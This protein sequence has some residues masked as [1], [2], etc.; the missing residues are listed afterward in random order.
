MQEDKECECCKIDF[1]KLNKIKKK[2]QIKVEI[3]DN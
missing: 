2:K 3:N 1:G